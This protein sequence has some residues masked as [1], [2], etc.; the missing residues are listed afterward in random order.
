MSAM[1]Q[2]QIVDLANPSERRAFP[3]GRLDVFELGE[4][5]VGVA[6]YDPGC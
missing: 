1:T 4:R 2:L 3:F 5:Q 6:T